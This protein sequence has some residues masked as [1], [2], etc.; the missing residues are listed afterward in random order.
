VISGSF[1]ES[2]EHLRG[3]LMG[4]ISHIPP[5]LRGSQMS[6]GFLKKPTSNL[7]LKR[8]AKGKSYEESRANLYSYKD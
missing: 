8:Q 5:E 1:D 6:G 2:E 7:M 3:V 4:D